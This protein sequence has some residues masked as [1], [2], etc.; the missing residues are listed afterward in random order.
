VSLV[1]ALTPLGKVARDWKT[2][3]SAVS[4]YTL[5]GLAVA[6]GV[7]ALLGRLG[8]LA[9][10]APGRQGVLLAGA[11]LALLLA[12][13]EWGLVRFRV[14]ERPLQTEKIWMHQFGPLGAATLWGLHL[15][16]GFFT[17]VNY[18]G[19][20]LVTLLAVGLGDPLYG[21][22]LV[23]GHW[24]GKALPVWLAPLV[25]RDPSSGDELLVV[26]GSRAAIYSRLQGLGLLAAAAVLALWRAAAGGME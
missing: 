7:G 1:G 3:F 5:S 9:G 21:A 8:R 19:F 18:G 23:G 14:P 16:L 26:W 10:L 22:S 24:L 20:W 17:R 6:A 13:R 11:G 12:A 4:L 2:W 25:Y 15:S